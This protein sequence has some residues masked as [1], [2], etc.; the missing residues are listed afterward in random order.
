MPMAGSYIHNSVEVLDPWVKTTGFPSC[1]YL[2]MAGAMS[3]LD[4]FGPK[5][6]NPDI[7]GPVE[8]IPTSADGVILS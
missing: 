4:T 8:S 1:I 5:L 7:Q 2:N 3:H 6:N